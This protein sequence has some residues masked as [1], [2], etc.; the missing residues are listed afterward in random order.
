[1]QRASLIVLVLFCFYVGALMTV[2]PWS[3]RYWDMNSWMHAHP[4][5]D[6]VL[7]RGW[8]RGLFSGIGL[9][10]LWIGI[11]ELLSYRDYRA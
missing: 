8:V 2:L 7:Q 10:D 5:I 11:S 3:P 9:L 4:M 6:N 1:M